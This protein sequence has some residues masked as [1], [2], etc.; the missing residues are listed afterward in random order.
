MALRLARAEGGLTEDPLR[1]GCGGVVVLVQARLSSALQL[2]RSSRT[3]H[4][5]MS[6]SVLVGHVRGPSAQ[7]AY[8]MA[9]A[10]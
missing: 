6:S 10:L 4:R 1:R 3:F 9:G 5:R 7:Q 8:R 2:G